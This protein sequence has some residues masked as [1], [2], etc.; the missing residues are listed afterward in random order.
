M[1]LQYGYLRGTFGLPY[2]GYCIRPQCLEDVVLQADNDHKQMFC[3]IGRYDEVI[4]WLD[5]NQHIVLN[6]SSMQATFTHELIVEL[7]THSSTLSR[8]IWG[9]K[10]LNV[11]LVIRIARTWDRNNDLGSQFHPLL[12]IIV[13]SGISLPEIRSELD[14]AQSDKLR[15]AT[16]NKNLLNTVLSRT[17]SRGTSS[18]YPKRN[19]GT[20]SPSVLPAYERRDQLP[21]SYFD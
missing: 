12:K 6:H 18:T 2:G 13:P 4:E 14:C 17:S 5:H 3:V 15:D 8:A 19:S 20:L 16:H 9:L 21:P 1:Q 11:Q 10:K 7:Y